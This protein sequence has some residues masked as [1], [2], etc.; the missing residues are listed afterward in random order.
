MSPVINQ[1]PTPAGEVSWV[2]RV[3]RASRFKELTLLS[4]MKPSFP[5]GK[6]DG[7]GCW[8]VQSEIQR[9][10]CQWKPCGKAKIMGIPET[11]PTWRLKMPC[12]DIPAVF[13]PWERLRVL[14]S[15][16]CFITAK[17]IKKS[18]WR[19]VCC[20]YVLQKRPL[21]LCGIWCFLWIFLFNLWS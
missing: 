13:L 18:A 8:N 21:Q 19:Q 2:K 9:C 11:Q 12:Q 1:K 4:L 10:W 5:A 16:Y 15:W 14:Q 17:A 20:Y 6:R 7:L 3:L